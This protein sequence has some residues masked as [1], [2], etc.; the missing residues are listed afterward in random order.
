MKIILLDLNY[1]L[2]EKCSFYKTTYYPEA[3]QYSQELVGKLEAEY[4]DWNIHLVTARL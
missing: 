2:A 3:D 1:T 4:S